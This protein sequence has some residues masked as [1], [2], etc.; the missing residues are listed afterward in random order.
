MESGNKTQ[1]LYSTIP[2]TT[3]PH[4][5][6]PTRPPL[7]VVFY[8]LERFKSQQQYT[9]CTLYSSSHQRK[10][11]CLG[12]RPEGFQGRLEEIARNKGTVR[13]SFKQSSTPIFLNSLEVRLYFSIVLID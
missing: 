13:V 7:P 11:L 5:S 10:T 8:H 9:Y 12:G 3:T 2:H 1:G 6:R 4:A